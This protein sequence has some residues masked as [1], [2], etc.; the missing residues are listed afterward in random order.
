MRKWQTKYVVNF[1]T[2]GLD[3]DIEEFA[4]DD[5]RG[6]GVISEG[7]DEIKLHSKVRPL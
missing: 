7:L 4:V 3:V 2:L 5:G 6:V 1:K